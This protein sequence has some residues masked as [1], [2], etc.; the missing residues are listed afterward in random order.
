MGCSTLLLQEDGT[1][2]LENRV[3]ILLQEELK[4]IADDEVVPDN[5]PGASDCSEEPDAQEKKEDS[6]EEYVNME[7]PRVGTLE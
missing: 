1:T 3:N 4:G 5:E 6:T 7:L 2:E